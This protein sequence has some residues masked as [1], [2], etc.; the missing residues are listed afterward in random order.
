MNVNDGS[1]S[2]TI[3]GTVSAV[4]GVEGLYKVTYQI[5]DSTMER[6]LLVVDRRIGDVNSDGAVN[7]ID[8]NNLVGKD[9]DANGVKQARIW[10]VNKDGRIDNN[11]VNA[12]RNRFS[13]R[14]EA[15][16]PWL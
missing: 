8:A 5:N 11:D 13:V 12:I 4:S 15:Y 2:D 14:L 16:Y 10:D 6:Y 9:A 1:T 7:G 3:K